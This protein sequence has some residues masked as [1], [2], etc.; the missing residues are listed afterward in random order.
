MPLKKAIGW[1]ALSVSYFANLA[2]IPCSMKSVPFPG[3]KSFWPG[4]DCQ[5]FDK[6]KKGSWWI[7]ACER[8]T[9]HN[10]IEP[11]LRLTI[12]IGI[13]LWK[14]WFEPLN[15]ILGIPLCI[16]PMLIATKLAAMVF[17]VDLLP[18][19]FISIKGMDLCVYFSLDSVFG[20]RN[21]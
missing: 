17:S 10:N 19:L 13:C 20:H 9:M 21:L 8:L 7:H 15:F 6:Y 5:S 3:H 4:Q 1:K 16:S 14:P 12:W 18:C 11:I 2:T